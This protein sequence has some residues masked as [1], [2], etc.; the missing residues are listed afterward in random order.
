MSVPG[1]VWA[2][3]DQHSEDLVSTAEDLLSNATQCRSPGES[4]LVSGPFLL[5]VGSPTNN[6][7][8]K[9]RISGPI[10]HLLN[11]NLHFSKIP[12]HLCA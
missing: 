4:E 7:N 3:R 8:R 6:E 10:L 11:Q 2:F 1:S 5:K 9:S 12:G